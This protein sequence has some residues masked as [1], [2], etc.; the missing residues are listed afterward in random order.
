M[1]KR[2][3]ISI[4]GDLSSGK[5]TVTKLMQETLG[6]EIYRNGEYFRKLAAEKGMSVTEFNVYVKEH[7]EIDRQ[8]EQSA[9]EYAA[10]HENLIID[11]RLG[12]YAV[13]ES[14]KIYLRV[15]INEAAKRAFG[16]PN[17]K[18]TENFATVE[19]QKQDMIKR[20]NLENERYFN[21][22]GV[23]KEDMANY[24]FV[25]DTTK[26]TPEEVNGKIIEAYNKWLEE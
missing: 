2:K 8:I 9:K 23:H 14:F 13:P 3:I 6:Y 22:Y 7:P 20:F 5:T 19:E 25:L 18:K 24:D 12:W 1:S 16:D 4:A 21:L 26:L 11:A 17:R 10:E 15:D